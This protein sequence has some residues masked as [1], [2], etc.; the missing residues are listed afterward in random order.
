MRIKVKMTL[1]LSS[2]VRIHRNHPAGLAEMKVCAVFDHVHIETWE[3]K[4]VR[5]GV[6]D[7]SAWFSQPQTGPG[8]R[9]CPSRWWLDWAVGTRE[10]D[11]CLF[12]P[13]AEPDSLW[14]SIVAWSLFP[15]HTG[16]LW[17]QQESVTS[18]SVPSHGCIRSSSFLHHKSPFWVCH[19][20]FLR[21]WM[22]SCEGNSSFSTLVHGIWVQNKCQTGLWR[23]RDATTMQ[24]QGAERE[25]VCH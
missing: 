16:R 5:G 6:P 18:K 1:F 8:G 24:S 17:G 22:V 13:C 23:G 25:D 11:L 9:L 10:R 19:R 7:S 15:G 3:D 12:G 2:A 14:P 21:T 4:M 20:V